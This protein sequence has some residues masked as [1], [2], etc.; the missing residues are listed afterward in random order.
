MNP[1]LV[2]RF[3]QAPLFIA[4]TSIAAPK[5]A[6]VSFDALGK[7]ECFAFLCSLCALL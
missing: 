1:R 3:D 5:I 7:S 4:M 2:D 6:S